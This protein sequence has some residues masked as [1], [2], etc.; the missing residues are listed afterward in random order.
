MPLIRDLSL[1][2]QHHTP[3]LKRVLNLPHPLPETLEPTF[4]R[5]RNLRVTTTMT[6]ESKEPEIVDFAAY[7]AARINKLRAYT[8]EV[9][10]DVRFS[11]TR[12]GTIVPAPTLVAD[13]HVLAVLAWCLD[14]SS[15]MLDSYLVL[16]H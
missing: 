14:V 4:N 3:V 13:L 10:T 15:N 11:I 12:G 7:R 9:V 8:E 2:N 6:R 5:P 1:A 16:A